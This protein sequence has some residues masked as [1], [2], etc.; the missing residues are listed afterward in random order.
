[1][2]KKNL[3]LV[4]VLL[5]YFSKAQVGQINIEHRTEIE[6]LATEG[7]KI[8]NAVLSQDRKV[9][10]GLFKS[11]LISLIE[12]DD[13][14]LLDLRKVSN[15]MQV[16]N[17]DTSLRV[18]TWTIL[19]AT[20][21]Y[22]YHGIIQRINNYG[23]YSWAELIDQSANIENPEKQ[24]LTASNWYGCLY[25]DLITVNNS[26]KDIHTL[27]GWDGNNSMTS[28]KV[29]E[30][31][32]FGVDDTARF[33]TPIIREAKNEYL[34]RKIFEFSA[35]LKMTLDIQK[36][37]KRIIYDHLSPSNPSLRGVYEYYGPDLTF[38]SYEWG[39]QF[40]DHYSDIDSDQN[41]EKSKKDFEVKDR[42]TIRSKNL[43]IPN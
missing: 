28:K 3:F 25:Y 11:T 13:S 38:D 14:I 12:L 20:N 1:M 18:L 6:I 26:L 4:L 29:V 34:Y 40:W 33:G 39:G 8:I 22:N 37:I 9:A 21:T 32:Y 19:D 36:D 42:D 23:E 24:E 17:A 15:L 7:Q 2:I 5:T 30:N 27:V 43:F 41:L 16:V 31:L 10:N 35:D